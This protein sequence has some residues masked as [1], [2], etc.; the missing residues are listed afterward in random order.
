MALTILITI[1]GFIVHSNP[2]NMTLSTFPEKSL[3]LEKLFLIFDPSPNVAPKPG[4]D[5]FRRCDVC[6]GRARYPLHVTSG[7]SNVMQR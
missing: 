3:K 1:C 5:S 6:E 2:N 4:E 7:E